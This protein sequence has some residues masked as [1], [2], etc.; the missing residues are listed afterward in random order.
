MKTFKEIREGQEELT[1]KFDPR[2]AEKTLKDIQKLFAQVKFIDR[3]KH[4]LKRWD[5]MWYATWSRWF[6]SKEMDKMK[7]PTDLK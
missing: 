7:L 3:D 6:T 1:E 4:I 2:K 5:D